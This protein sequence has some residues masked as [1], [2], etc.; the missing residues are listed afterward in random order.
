MIRKRDL[1]VILLYIF[2]FLLLWEW[3]RPLEQLTDMGHIEVFVIFLLI[4]FLGSYFQIKWRLQFV[5]KIIYILL[6]LNYLFVGKWWASF[7]SD[8]KFIFTRNWDQLSDEFRTF[9]FFI[10]LWMM[11]YLIHYWILRRQRI[12]VFFLMTLVYITVLDAFTPYSAKTAIIRTVICGFAMMGMLT[13]YRILGKRDVKKET[14]DTKKWMI[15]LSGML[16]LSVLIGYA[17]PKAAPIWP[18]P[19]SY[20]KSAK[21]GDAGGVGKIGYGENDTHLGGPFVGDNTVVF[22]VVAQD[23]QYWKV[24]TKDK[25][26]GKGWMASGSTPITFTPSELVPV[27][28]IPNTVSKTLKNARIYSYYRKN[29]LVYPAGITAIDGP[30]KLRIDTNSEKIESFDNEQNPVSPSGYHIFFEVPKY[31]SEDLA[32]TTDFDFEMMSQNFERYT[33]LPK[34]LPPRIK[35]L[36]EEI[37]AG[38]TNWFDKAKAIESYFGRIDFTYDQKN[39]AVPGKNDDYVDQFLFE[40]KRGYCDN[41]STSMAVMLRTLGI[42]TR[43]VKGFTGGNF[44]EFENETE[45][46][47]QITNNNA[48]SWV[49][50]FFPNQGWVPFEPTK[51]FTNNVEIAYPHVNPSTSSSQTPVPE[52]PKKDP[53]L[54]QLE[55]ADKSPRANKSFDIKLLW[56]NTKLFLKNQWKWILLGLV[57][58]GVAIAFLYEIRGKWIPRYLLICYRYKKDDQVLGAAYLTLLKQLDRYGI[59]RKKNQTLRGY[60]DYVDDYFSTKDMTELTAYYEQMVYNQNLQKGSWKEVRELWENLIKMTIA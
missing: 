31:K 17:A 47:Y 12:F 42:P 10:L 29:Y 3:L 34:D 1:S 58:I 51:G 35:Q 40:T 4:C 5:I 25:Y 30:Q 27:F 53:R 37:T 19:V 44:K 26:T 28:S 24:E 56:L 46:I 6:S 50:V 45:R 8:I 39:V 18:D 2:S 23:K 7:F 54:N 21:D 15:P 11:A 14:S 20:F 48:H 55:D 60:A 16:L 49:E 22:K 13:Y 32:K 9:L 43:W 52:I 57:L 33:R 41:F 38:K 36:A 59:K